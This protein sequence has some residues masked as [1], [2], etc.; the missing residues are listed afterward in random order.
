MESEDKTQ[1]WES[2]GVR[3]QVFAARC[4]G[5]LQPESEWLIAARSLERRRGLARPRLDEVRRRIDQVNG[6]VP[7]YSE[8]RTRSPQT[9]I[10]APRFNRLKP[11]TVLDPQLQQHLERFL[12]FRLP[13]IQ[14]HTTA[15]ADRAARRVGAD[16][17]TSR[18]AIYFR[19]GAFQPA[20]PSGRALLAHEATHIAWDR[21]ARPLASPAAEPAAREER[22]A[23]ANEYR[24]LTRRESLPMSPPAAA[25][26]AV[27]APAAA[28][29]AFFKTALSSRDAGDSS[30]APPPQSQLS[31]ASVRILQDDLYRML[32]D[33][34]RSDFERGA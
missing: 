28:S 2:P 29:P 23:L 14:I 9:D 7:V 20:T 27:T 5:R 12:R 22:S 3:W 1:A 32:L 11:H 19:Q 8:L 17:V 24:Y 16:A 26:P 10:E 30:S 18:N 33:K 13:S 6:R 4:R 34:L 21:G 15:A 25:S 31:E